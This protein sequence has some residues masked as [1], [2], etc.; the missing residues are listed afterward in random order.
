MSF[1][2]ILNWS[3]NAQEERTPDIPD[4]IDFLLLFEPFGQ[5]AWAVFECDYIEEMES[6]RTPCDL[7][8]LIDS[9]K[10]YPPALAQSK[11]DVGLQPFRADEKEQF[12][13]FIKER[14]SY[15]LDRQG[16]DSYQLA[17][18]VDSGIDCLTGA[19]YWIRRIGPS[20]VECI[21]RDY[22]IYKGPD[23]FFKPNNRV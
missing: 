18:A 20:L 15:H 13:N 17:C 23:H 5:A 16:E 2:Y 6:F 7:A 21:S 12:L 1:Y 22:F 9:A 8:L 10:D 4:K 14:L 11:R 3:L 19:Y